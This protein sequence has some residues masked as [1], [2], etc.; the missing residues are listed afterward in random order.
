MKVY[1]AGPWVDR[2][3]VQALASRLESEGH[4]ITHPW[5]V[6]EGA[7]SVDEPN[8]PPEY[9]EN[10]AKHDRDGVY[11]ADVVLVWNSSKSEGKAVEQGLAIAWNKPI[12]CITPGAKHTVNI[13]HFLKENYTHVTTFEEALKILSSMTTLTTL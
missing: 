2:H 3:N 13:F 8:I 6:F 10:C 1:F 7:N 9:S 12:I 5:W 4:E 11:E